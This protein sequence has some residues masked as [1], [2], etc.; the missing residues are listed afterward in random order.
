MLVTNITFAAKKEARV[1]LT[2]HG[3]KLESNYSESMDNLRN[4]LRQSI[5]KGPKGCEGSQNGSGNH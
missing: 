1:E 3:K 2:D 5:P 4:D